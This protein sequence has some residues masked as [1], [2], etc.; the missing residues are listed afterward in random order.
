MYLFMYTK[1]E[2][3]HTLKG[4]RTL[5]FLGESIACTSFFLPKIEFQEVNL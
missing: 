2:F 5:F 4:K 3:Y 1:F